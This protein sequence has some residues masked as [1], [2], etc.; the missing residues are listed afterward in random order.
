[1]ERWAGEGC[2]ESRR[3]EGG[4]GGGSAD[5]WQRVGQWVKKGRWGTRKSGGGVDKKARLLTRCT[6]K[7]P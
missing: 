2:G 3:E 5:P 1:V 6:E 7:K 4:E